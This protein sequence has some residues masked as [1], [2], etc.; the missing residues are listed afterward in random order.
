MHYL[1]PSKNWFFL[2]YDKM[3]KNIG[4][5]HN[6]YTIEIYKYWLKNHDINFKRSFYNRFNS[7]YFG[8]D[9][10]DY[11]KNQGFTIGITS[12]ELTY[13]Y[14]THKFLKIT[15][16]KDIY[17]SFFSLQYFNETHSALK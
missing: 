14:I 8:L 9:Q 2:D 13:N 17:K 7:L 6:Q 1:Y 15:N 10:Y 4:G 16:N 5:Y 11:F 3:L 12:E